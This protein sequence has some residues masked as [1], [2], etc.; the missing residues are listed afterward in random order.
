MLTQQRLKEVLQYN[1][2]SGLFQWRSPASRRMKVGDKAGV[3]HSSGY[4][5]IKVDGK[6]YLGH[7]LAWLYMNGSMPERQIDHINGIRSDNRMEN[8]RVASH[9]ENMC[10]KRQPQCN[11]KAGFLG[12]SLHK[13]T[14]KYIAQIGINGRYRNLGYF[15]TPEQAH[16][17]YIQAKREMHMFCTI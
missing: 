14:G 9:S 2:E 7:R 1:H 15:D 5:R 10:N 17:R 6:S 13:P 11:N 16:E 4:V 8:L 3:I 12:V